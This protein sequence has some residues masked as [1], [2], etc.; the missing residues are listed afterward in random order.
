LSAAS[1]GYSAL[2]PGSAT[3]PALI[4]A[5]P[6]PVADFEASPWVTT[7][8]RPEV[9][10]ADLSQGASG[11]VW[12]FGL[13]DGASTE[14]SPEF[15]YDSIGCYAV[16]LLAVSDM[17]C[18]SEAE[19][20]VCVEP[21]FALWVPNAFTP[22]GDGLNDAFSAVTSVLRPAE[23]ELAVFDRWGRTIFIG[24]SPDERWD[25]DG[26]PIGL[27]AWR[28]RLRDTLGQRHERFGHVLLAR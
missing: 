22:D 14:R 6:L 12:S 21:P 7:I 27:Y 13:H 26:A 24:R 5:W 19:G 18:S 2:C 17:G 8:E 23:F 25:G 16:R 11:L 4:H 20:Q 9:R 28:L 3:Q 10:F 1:N 15:V